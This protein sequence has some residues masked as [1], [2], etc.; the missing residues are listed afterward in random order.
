MLAR[1]LLAST[2]VLCPPYS[3]WTDAVSAPDDDGC[4]LCAVTPGA[5]HSISV[6]AEEVEALRRTYLGYCV[7][8]AVP[9]E[10]MGV[11]G[12]IRHLALRSRVLVSV[13]AGP[14]EV[15]RAVATAIPTWHDVHSWLRIVWPRSLR[16]HVDYCTELLAGDVPT[17]AAASA[18]HREL[19]GASLPSPARWLRMRRALEV[20]ALLWADPSLPIERAASAGGFHDSATFSRSLQRIS[21]CRPGYARRR[22][23]WE[24]MLCGFLGL[25][26]ILRKGQVLGHGGI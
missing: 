9:R 5:Q 13:D 7:V 8:C 16:S 11:L 2:R 21:G 1:G 4:V 12:A 14:T 26:R 3:S 25:P 24:W 23:G 20:M 6:I 18:V 22:V 17:G 19:K 10:L 15:V